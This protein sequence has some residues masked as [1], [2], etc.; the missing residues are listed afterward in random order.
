MRAHDDVVVTRSSVGARDEAKL[1]FVG[2]RED[3]LRHPARELGV[4]VLDLCAQDLHGKMRKK[5]KAPESQNLEQRTSR[6]R[7]QRTRT[8]K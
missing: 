3:G 6:N 7:E 1:H 2:T 5:I 8:Q 4:V